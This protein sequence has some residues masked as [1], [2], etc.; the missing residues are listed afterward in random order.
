MR[1]E[2]HQVS[3][4]EMYFFDL[5]GYLVVPGIL[6][7]DEIDAVNR[8]L[9]AKMSD[10]V[11][12]EAGSLSG[13]AEN[14]TGDSGRTQ[15]TGM[16][17]WEPEHRAPFRRL[18]VHPVV[19]SR[20]NAFT[21]RGFRLDHGPLLISGRKGAEGHRLHGSGEP[22]GQSV[23]YH[24]QNGRIYC[25][26]VTV[27]WQLADCGPGDGG[28]A[29]V[30]GSHKTRE[31]TPDDVRTLNDDMGLVEQPVMRA[32]DVL[33]FAETATHGTLP[34]QADHERRSVLY[35]YAARGA[36]RAVGKYFTP[37]DRLGD[38]TKE[39][40]PEQQAV[41]YGPGVHHGGR[42]TFLDSDGEKAWVVN[43]GT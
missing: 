28:F 41:L 33:F 25:R 13:G 42:L 3:A 22:F 39:L 38:W 23:T 6:G 35:K 43:T 4:E 21:G 36:A 17:G 18:L 19:V 32:G 10:A 16:L 12:L 26:G 31:P 8:A 40:T 30:P 9:D 7:S 29:I 1:Y 5:R 20:L 2:H 14:L 15:I 37:E 27:A 11:T 24:Q 34:W